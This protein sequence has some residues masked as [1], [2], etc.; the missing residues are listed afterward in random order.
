[1][2]PQWKLKEGDKGLRVMLLQKSIKGR[3]GVKVNAVGDVVRDGK[4]DA[5]GWKIDPGP[6]DGV[7]GHRTKLAVMSFEHMHGVPANGVVGPMILERLN[8]RR[9]LRRARRRRKSR[10]LNVISRSRWGAAPP[11]GAIGGVSEP[12]TQFFLHCDVAG[13]LPADA[14]IE[15][16]C[17]VMRNLQGIAFARGFFDISYSFVQF[18]SGRVYEGRGWDKA[19]AHT[20]GFNSSTYAVAFHNS[21]TA[22]TK[23]TPA[24]V[25]GVKKLVQLGVRT[26]AMIRNLVVRGHRDVTAKS[27]PGDDAYSKR[28]EIAEAARAA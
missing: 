21:C 15:Q 4:G 6:A 14:T 9:K 11:R 7:F 26:G 28:G 17:A 27:C 25:A 12:T 13:D 18:A 20:E 5:I 3:E 24:A 16:E 1:M 19:G 10:Q 2:S 22:A 8:L 23:I